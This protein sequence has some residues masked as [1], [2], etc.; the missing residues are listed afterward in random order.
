MIINPN[1]ASWAFQNSNQSINQSDSQSISQYL[2][3]S[4]E[5]LRNSRWNIK[6]QHV[7]QLNTVYGHS[8]SELNNIQWDS[9]IITFLYLTLF[10]FMWL[11][12]FCSDDAEVR[13]EADFLCEHNFT[14]T[15]VQISYIVPFLYKIIN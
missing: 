11:K 2:P 14:D 4:E 5:N 13:I 6:S 7:L 10:L 1:K 3:L 9:G 15:V 8:G 12:L